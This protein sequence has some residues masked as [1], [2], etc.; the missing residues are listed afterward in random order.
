MCVYSSSTGQNM[1]TDPLKLLLQMTVS[2]HVGAENEPG[3]LDDLSALNCW[4]ISLDPS[5][6]IHNAQI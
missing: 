5:S 2:L 1:V 4:A 6:N 3:L